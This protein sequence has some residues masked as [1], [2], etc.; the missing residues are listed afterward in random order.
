MTAD[1]PTEEEQAE[2]VVWV[3]QVYEGAD[4]TFLDEGQEPLPL[5]QELRSRLPADGEG[6]RCSEN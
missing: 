3:L 1:A 6:H 2:G 4:M 5:P